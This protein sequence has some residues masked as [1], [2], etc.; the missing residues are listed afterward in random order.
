MNAPTPDPETVRSRYTEEFRIR[1]SDRSPSGHVNNVSFLRYLDEARTAFLAGRPG[2]G[3]V[4][5]PVLDVVTTLVAR[6]VVEYRREIFPDE[7]P[8][9]LDLWVPRIGRTSFSVAAHAYGRSS[10]EPAAIFDSTVVL[11][12]RATGQ[13]WPID[14]ATRQLLAAY[15][16][17]PPALR[18]TAG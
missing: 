18:T 2:R 13:P 8:V 15:A 17:P 14:D 4:L 7:E 9:R 10:D 5:R 1:L 12:T 3:G 11:A 16:G 6:N